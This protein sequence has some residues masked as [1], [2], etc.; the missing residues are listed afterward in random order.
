[1]LRNKIIVPGVAWCGRLVGMKRD[2]GACCLPWP[3]SEVYFGF[4]PHPLIVVY[5]EYIGTLI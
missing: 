1:M 3:D 2:S 5:Q 4:G